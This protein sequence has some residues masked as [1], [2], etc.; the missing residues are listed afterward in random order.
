[1]NLSDKKIAVI[2]LGYVGLPLAVAFA[3][4]YPVVGFDVNSIRVKELSIG[5]DKTLEIETWE[6]EKVICKNKSLESGKVGLRISTDDFSIKEA[7]IYIITVPTPI[8]KNNRPLLTPMI[9]ASKTVASYLKK[10]DIVIYE[11]TVYPGVTEEEMVPILEK[12]SGL[13]YN[14]DFYCGYSPERINPGDKEH[15]FTKILKIKLNYNILISYKK[16]KKQNVLFVSKKKNIDH[17]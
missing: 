11:S 7:N 10:G 5:I 4:K 8:D 17:I 2:G 6:L 13:I 3:S 16:N 14:K 9:L 12:Y 1:M 15:T